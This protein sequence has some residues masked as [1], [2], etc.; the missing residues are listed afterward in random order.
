MLAGYLPFDD[1]PANPE[2]DNINLLYKYICTTPLVFPEYVSPHSR[3][4]LRRI[5][6]PDPTKRADLFEVARHSWLGEFSRTVEA[7]T[8]GVPLP[9]EKR[10]IPKFPHIDDRTDPEVFNS[11]ARSN[12]LKE[13]TKTHQAPS[14]LGGPTPKHG[15]SH[16]DQLA[17]AGKGSKTS[18]D[19]KRRTVQVEYVP[20]HTQTTRGASVNEMSLPSNQRSSLETRGIDD[21]PPVPPEK[22]YPQRQ[23]SERRTGRNAPRATTDSNAFSENANFQGMRPSTAGSTAG[24]L[25]LPPSRGSYGQPSAAAVAPTNAQG[26]FSRPQPPNNGLMQGDQI[27]NHHGNDQSAQDSTDYSQ[28]ST[29]NPGNKM[30]RRGHKRAATLSGLGEKILDRASS[31]RRPG[32]RRPKPDRTH[33]PTSMRPMEGEGSPRKSTDSRRSFGFP[34]K[35]SDLQSKDKRGSRRFSLLPRS[36]GEHSQYNGPTQQMQQQPIKSSAGPSPWSDGATGTQ[37]TADTFSQE[38]WSQLPGKTRRFNDAYDQNEGAGSSGAARRVMEF[39]RR[40]K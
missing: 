1:D 23:V 20:P 24:G 18:R 25:R 6:V 13:S 15:H 33:P 3:D 29:E 2:G 39:F 4:I 17:E 9:E 28:T 30:H 35:T 27:P 12:S 10:K 38:K 31:V 34:R 37:G 36:R 32:A 5:L 21:F 8:S 16:I 11:L 19:T 14:P 7:I 26:R 22:D 40:R